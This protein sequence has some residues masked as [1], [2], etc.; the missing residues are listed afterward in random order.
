MEWR[1][2]SESY[3]FGELCPDQTQTTPTF[4]NDHAQFVSSASDYLSLHERV[5]LLRN[6]F[7]HYEDVREL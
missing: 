7:K 5:I 6:S 1:V 3:D 4:P 2:A